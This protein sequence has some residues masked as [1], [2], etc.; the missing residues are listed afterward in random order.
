MKTCF[1]IGHRDT[2]ANAYWNLLAAVERAV[3]WGATNF[4][5]GCDGRFDRLAARAVL[6]VKERCP[7]LTL[8]CLLP[9]CLSEQPVDLPEGFDSAFC[10]PGMENAPGRM[11]IV[12]ASQSMIDHCD[13]LI[14]HV[15][16][17]SERAYPLLSYAQKRADMGLLKIIRI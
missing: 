9:C 13:L 16:Y 3:E 2:P 7:G 1:F 12:Q 4:V 14:S 5:V 11:D 6:K 10:S 15:W 17:I 8:T